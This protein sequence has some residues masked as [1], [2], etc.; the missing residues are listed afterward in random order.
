MRYLALSI[1]VTC[2]IVLSAVPHVHAQSTPVLTSVRIHAHSKTATLGKGSIGLSALAYDQDNNPIGN[3]V[4][5]E[6]GVSSSNSIGSVH[7][8]FGTVSNFTPLTMGTG[9]VFVIA[10][11]GSEMQAAG[12][13][14]T[15]VAPPSPADV[16]GDGKVTITDLSIVLSNFG[17]VS[18]VSITGDVN[19]DRRVNMQ[20]LS[21]LLA[22]F[23]R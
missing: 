7:P 17:R 4:T 1:I 23:G 20:D 18:S 14:M 16:S 6:W 8:V 2:F 12:I 5:Y 19:G 11:R 10:R 13:Q 9:D 22:H 21:V 3:G 15:V